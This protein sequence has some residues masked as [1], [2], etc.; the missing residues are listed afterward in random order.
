MKS[1]NKF[2][3][4][5]N[6]GLNKKILTRH[7]MTKDVL[8]S[9]SNASANDNPDKD[10]DFNASDAEDTT[11]SVSDADS[12]KVKKS[13][14]K[15]AKKSPK[16]STKKKA[17]KKSNKAKKSPAKA[18]GKKS[19]IVE[20]TDPF[21]DSDDEPEQEVEEEYEVEAIVGHREYN[22]KLVYKIRWK[23][24]GAASDTWEAADSLSCPNI[25]EPYNLKV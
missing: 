6:I 25:L 14:K 11:A 18:E 17:L 7:K 21:A 3:K 8:D 1:T 4:G 12:T 15:L 24:Y 10:E 2:S 19:I 9:D 23:G 16:K 22:G 13:P 5:K 20:E